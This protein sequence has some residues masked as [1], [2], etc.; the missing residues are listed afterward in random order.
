MES[1][2]QSFYNHHAIN[3]QSL[4]LFISTLKLDVTDRPTDRPTD[5][6]CPILSSIVYKSPLPFCLSLVIEL[7]ALCAPISLIT[8]VHLASSS[9]LKQTSLTYST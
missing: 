5:G 4:Y 3:L 1:I 6:H 9:S 8:K 7:G 2:E